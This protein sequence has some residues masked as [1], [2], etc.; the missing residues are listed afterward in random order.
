MNLYE[1]MTMAKCELCGKEP[2]FGHNVSHS[3]RATNR[4]FKPNVQKR[5]IEIGGQRRRRYVCAQCLRT[6][7]KGK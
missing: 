7:N 1:V 5:L 6:L 2:Q 3:K 4:Q